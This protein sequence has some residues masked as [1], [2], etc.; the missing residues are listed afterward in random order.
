MLLGVARCLVHA[1]CFR[2]VGEGKNAG[3]DTTTMLYLITAAQVRKKAYISL[4]CP[5]L[6]IYF[7]LTLPVSCL[8][9]Q[10]L[11]AFIDSSAA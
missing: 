4:S 6:R 7:Y 8:R 10:S 3:L 1:R 2:D 11:P 5:L 9:V